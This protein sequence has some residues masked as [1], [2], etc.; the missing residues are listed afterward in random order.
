MSALEETVGKLREGGR[1]TGDEAL[2]LWR[3]APLWQLGELAVAAKRRVS[4]DQ[5][6]LQPQFPCR[7]DE[8]VRLQLQVLFLPP[9][10]RKSR[11][12]GLF[13]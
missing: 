11:V 6:L 7:A 13:A 9:A 4:G 5:G 8:P 1:I 10:E 12:V 3:E 2:A